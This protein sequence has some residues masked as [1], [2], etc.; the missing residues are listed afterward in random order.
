MMPVIWTSKRCPDCLGTG[1]AGKCLHCGHVRACP[2]CNG[3]GIVTEVKREKDDLVLLG[4][5]P[6]PAWRLGG[7]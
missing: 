4:R 5:G 2:T 3:T 1:E 6:G 7:G